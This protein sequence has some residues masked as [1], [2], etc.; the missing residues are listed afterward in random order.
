MSDKKEHSDLYN[1][2]HGERW[3]LCKESECIAEMNRMEDEATCKHG[4]LVGCPACE[5]ETVELTSD[6]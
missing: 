4:F 3:F 1:C 6:N 5:K 2:P